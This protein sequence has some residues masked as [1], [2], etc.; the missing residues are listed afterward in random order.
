MA[1]TRFGL[2]E[3]HFHLIQIRPIYPASC[4]TEVRLAIVT[5]ADHDAVDA[6]GSVDRFVSGVR[7]RARCGLNAESREVRKVPQSRLS[8]MSL[9][10][11]SLP[12]SRLFR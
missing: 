5:Y 9:A 3:M 2:S 7:F 11:R 8:L 1:L 12:L 6:D 4:L 10:A